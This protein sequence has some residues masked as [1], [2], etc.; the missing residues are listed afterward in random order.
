M[1]D[2]L[3]AYNKVKYPQAAEKL[4]ALDKLITACRG[5]L[6]LPD[7][8]AKRKPGVDALR[9]EANAERPLVEEFGRALGAD[10][11]AEARA[12]VKVEDQVV[13]AGDSPNSPPGAAPSH[14][15]IPFLS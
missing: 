5:H 9:A 3:E 11:L 10:G 8:E 1:D 2:A 6:A 15:S 7:K 14:P 13:A 12:L 4:T